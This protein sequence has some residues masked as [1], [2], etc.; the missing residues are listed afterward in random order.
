MISEKVHNQFKFS[1]FFCFSTI[2]NAI[3]SVFVFVQ[4]CAHFCLCLCL[5][6]GHTVSPYPS[7]QL[8]ERPQVFTI[9]LQCSEDAI[10]AKMS[11]TLMSDT[12]TS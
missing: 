1:I 2:S 7:D 5:L 8:S 6:I 10:K 12:V 3:V 4:L 9:A 11:L